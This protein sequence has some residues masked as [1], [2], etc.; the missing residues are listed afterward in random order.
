MDDYCTIYH[1]EE[2]S[3]HYRYG[4]AIIVVKGTS[5]AFSNADLYSDRI[6]INLF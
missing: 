2:D 6:T 5:Y 3:K 1:T 4:I